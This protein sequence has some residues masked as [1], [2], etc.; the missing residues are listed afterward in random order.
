MVA[1]GSARVR[2]AVRHLQEAIASGRWPVNSRIPS[3]PDL[4]AELGVGRSTVREAVGSLA[5][6][7]ML[8]P[9]PGRGTFVRS[10][11]PVHGVLS[12]FAAQHS[13]V[14]LLAVRKAL[15]V[16]A[17]ELAAVRHDAEGLA[18][19]RAAHAADREGRGGAE[20]GAAPG[21][22]HSL[23]IAMAQNRLL[24]DLYA[25][26]MSALRSGVAARQVCSGQDA[27]TRWAEHEALLAAIA[28]SNPSAAAAV[29]GAHA[30][31]DLREVGGSSH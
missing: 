7:G 8:E 13:W 10:L 20:R 26:L 24:E 31:H 16:Q 18:L 14:D 19:L 4:A 28:S 15:E 3:E 2:E 6:L 22:F 12:D 23:V 9:A 5:R 21:Q 27:P 30:D 1:L 25:A 11:S 17:A 29:A